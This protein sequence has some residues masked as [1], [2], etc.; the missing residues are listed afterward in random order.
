MKSDSGKT[1]RASTAS[2]SEDDSQEKRTIRPKAK[3]GLEDTGKF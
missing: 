2:T 3:S 1:P